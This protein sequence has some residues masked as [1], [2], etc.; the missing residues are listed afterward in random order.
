MTIREYFPNAPK[1]AT[2]VYLTPTQFA[3]LP[4]SARTMVMAIWLTLTLD[5]E[6]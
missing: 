5:D 4:A 3:A 2:G 1:T 6:D